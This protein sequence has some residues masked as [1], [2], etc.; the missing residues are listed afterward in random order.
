[1][2]P[3]QEAQKKRAM[4]EAELHNQHSAVDRTREA[5]MMQGE[6]DDARINASD[7]QRAFNT[8]DANNQYPGEGRS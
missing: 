4:E 2:T 1:M 7:A 5:R 8:R 3:S 6:R